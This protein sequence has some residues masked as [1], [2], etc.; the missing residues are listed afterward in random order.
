MQLNLAASKNTSLHT[1]G[2]LICTLFQQQKRISS[3]LLKQIM[4]ECCQGS[5]AAGVWQWKDAYE[6]V[7]I[8]LVKYLMANMPNHQSTAEILSRLNELER[9]YPT[10]N[11][12]TEKS[13][14]LQQFSTPVT[15]G[16]LASHA[17]GLTP[18][19][20]LLE[21]SAGNGLLAVFGNRC[22]QLILN[23]IDPQRRE[24]L[25]QL[26]ENAVISSH[27]AEQIHDRLDWSLKP[28]AILMNPPFTSFLNRNVRKSSAVMEHLINALKRLEPEGRLVI[29][30]QESIRPNN[31]IW[32]RKFIE[33]QSTAKVVFS[34]GIT[35]K[36]YARQGTWLETRLTVIDKIP[37]ADPKQFCPILPCLDLPELNKAIMQ[38]SPR[39]MSK[40]AN[41][42]ISSNSLVNSQKFNLTSKTAKREQISLFD[43]SSV[44][45][46]PS[47][48][49]SVSQEFYRRI[50]QQKNLE[51]LAGADILWK[52]IE[53]L[54]YEANYYPERERQTQDLYEPYTI[55]GI[56]IPQAKPHPTE[57]VESVAM[58]SIDPPSCSY[59]PLLPKSLIEKGLLSAP[60][61]ETI[62]RAGQAHS[63]LLERWVSIDS[64][65]NKATH[66]PYPE[67]NAKQERKGMILGD[68]TGC[69]KGR[70]VAGIIL[71][72]WLNKRQKAV[73]ISLSDKLL[74]DARRDWQDLG[75]NP[76]DVFIQSKHRANQKLGRSKGI[77]FTTYGT[78][79]QPAKNKTR[80]RIDQ[81]IEWLG[82]EFEGAIA[83]DEC[84]AMGG[85]LPVKGKR[86]L[87]KPS[88]QGLA[89]LELQNRLPNARVIYI[90][91]TGASQVEN[92]AYGERL[93]LW[94]ARNCAFG[95]RNQ[96]IEEISN[97]GLAAME[98]ISK[99][100]KAQGLYLARSLSYCGIEYQTIEHELTPEQVEIYNR[101]ADAY[102]VIHEN[103]EEALR[104][105]NANNGQTRCAAMSAFES[106][107]QRFFNQLLISMSLPTL[108]A[109]MEND[110][111]EGLAPV[112]Q[113]VSTNESM[114]DKQL[115]QIPV[116]EWDDLNLNISPKVYILEY[117]NNSFPIHLMET[118]EVD[119]TIVHYYATD[120]NGNRIVNQEALR[121][122]EQ[123][124]TDIMLLPTIH[125][126]LDQLIFH[127]GA[128]NIAE[129]TGRSI[130]L[131]KCVDETGEKIKVQKRSKSAN[132]TE[133]QAFMN[134]QKQILIFSDAGKTGR[135]YHAAKTARN[136]RQRIHYLLE[137]GWNAASAIQGFGRTHRSNQ[138]QPPVYRLV[139]TNVKG[140]KRFTSTI[141]AR[142]DALGAITKGQAATGSTGMFK[143]EDNLE[144]VYAR[145]ALHQLF[146]HIEQ[147]V[148][149]WITLA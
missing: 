48:I 24:N 70:Q 131:V 57:L 113:I 78:L 62:I 112:I 6:A 66:Y 122:K 147:N 106:T 30:S 22:Q 88:L 142:L 17:A 1:A 93:G 86:G 134:D 74:E 120:E 3:H 114:L 72:N 87:K 69:G 64:Q 124:L 80:S 49:P 11:K 101:Y 92:L 37:A 10:H 75:G 51:I 89:G 56:N 36:V 59:Q 45:K 82:E 29:I 16:Y 143:A 129:I 84:H 79:R 77:L 109:T 102:Q 25:E 121:R 42:S 99:D 73:W 63:Q 100:L 136:Q 47:I 141:A 148:F 5:D 95:D 110:L 94:G 19:D 137:A 91:A 145:L 135:S 18:E 55:R 52:D 118:H 127:F 139:T 50:P 13:I 44:P 130:R 116:A 132:L 108:M 107:K 117:L 67:A 53:L 128:D 144:S 83:F 26:F 21:P 96:F 38:I 9:L 76:S 103:I 119:S 35:G 104:A 133:A 33:I 4:T 7:E 60:Q 138:K 125:S 31:P 115:Q 65:N 149:C 12:R 46:T 98:I 61:L 71:D 40:T 41:H 81:I 58:N 23:E 105:S 8:G 15:L 68:G 43:L 123:M 54:D 34:A 32:V 39:K 90:S 2:D 27:N 140:Q 85:A 28:T 111:L 14:A 146:T 126:A 20:I 97:G